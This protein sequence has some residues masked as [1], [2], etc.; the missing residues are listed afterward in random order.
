[1][2]SKDLRLTAAEENAPSSSQVLEITLEALQTLDQA[3]ERDVWLMEEGDDSVFYSDEEQTNQDKK[4]NSSCDFGAKK[5]KCPVNS[6]AHKEPILQREGDPG[7]EAIIDKENIEMEKEVS[8]Q[9]ILAEK[10]LHAPKTETMYQ[11][12][13]AETLQPNC[14]NADVQTQPKPNISSETGKRSSV[15]LY[16]ET[17]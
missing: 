17:D 15:S 8:L 13:S 4:S 10:E 3:E 9:Y 7:A 14:T 1:M 16:D 6:E 2:T 11:S 12:D 5:S